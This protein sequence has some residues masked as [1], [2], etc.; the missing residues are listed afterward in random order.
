M[1]PMKWPNFRNTKQYF[2]YASL[3][4]ADQS[5]SHQLSGPLSRALQYD[6]VYKDIER[7]QLL[8]LSSI[9]LK[10]LKMCVI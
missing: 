4:N 1:S 8:H 7:L 10:P 2:E 6:A 5:L 9:F 3:R